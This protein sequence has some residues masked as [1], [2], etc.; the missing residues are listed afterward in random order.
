MSA[1]QQGQYELDG[2]IFGMG[3][4]NVWISNTAIDPG[5]MIVQ[6]TQMPG[7]D[8]IQFGIDIM[9]GLTI[10]YTGNIYVAPPFGAGSST[11]YQ[12]QAMDSY[13]Q[14]AGKWNDPS[15]RLND[16]TVV[17]LRMRYPFSASTRVIYGRGRKIM[18]TMGLVHSGVIPFV[19]QFQSGD[20]AV[21]QDVVQTLSMTMGKAPSGHH[22]PQGPGAP[23]YAS[24]FTTASVNNTGT[25]PTW[26][27]ITFTGPCQDPKLDYTDP[28]LSIGYKGFIAGNDTIIIDTRPW[29]RYA[30]LLSPGMQPFVTASLGG[31]VVALP[32]YLTLQQTANVLVGGGT[33]GSGPPPVAQPIAG[34]LTGNRLS[35]MSLP[36]GATKVKF[37]GTSNKGRGH[38]KL[39]WQSAEA[40]IG[41]FLS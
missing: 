19:A 22:P 21:Y 40:I 34:L 32:N 17:A 28:G 12:Q 8:G 16:N 26:P 1:L 10:T 35:D 13:S 30:T 5:A 27:V 29:A 4:N 31:G 33:G 2:F 23:P 7:V 20:W 9:A 3:A 14:L 37:T 25:L 36:P 24:N 18:P 41:G 15:V 39:Q 11:T 38:C 6:D